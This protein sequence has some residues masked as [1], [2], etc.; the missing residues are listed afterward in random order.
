[1]HNYQDL[2]LWQKALSLVKEI[3]QMTS[4]FPRE[5]MF[6]MTSQV[7]RSAIS[8]P[9]NIAEGAGRNG[10]KEFTH[11]LSISQGSSFELE[12]QMILSNDLG[13]ISHSEL[14]ELISRLQEIQKM[15][16]SLQNSFFN[17]P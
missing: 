12:T 17:R 11:F 3:Y 4:K 13:F 15:N 7:K 6:G 5:E 1:M 16:R 9:S 14:D 2:K 8:I 10:D